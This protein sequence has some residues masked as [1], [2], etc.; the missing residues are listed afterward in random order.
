MVE[1]T[2]TFSIG[3]V[4]SLLD[5]PRLQT[6]SENKVIFET[7]DLPLSKSAI[8]LDLIIFQ[9]AFIN[10]ALESFLFESSVDKWIKK[11]TQS[12]M[13]SPESSES[14]G[15]LRL[16]AFE[17]PRKFIVDSDASHEH[18]MGK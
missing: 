3:L 9:L 15:V 6:N 16:K 8:E 5:K 2:S 13:A 7:T 12:S 14:S 10:R 4:L 18:V 11:R 17:H 1:K